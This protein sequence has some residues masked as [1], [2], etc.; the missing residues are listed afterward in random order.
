MGFPTLL[1]GGGCCCCGGAGMDSHPEFQLDMQPADMV[2]SRDALR[3]F[4]CVY[5][6]FAAVRTV[7]FRGVVGWVCASAGVRAAVGVWR[8]SLS[9][10]AVLCR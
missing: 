3:R 1:T 10:A 4:G 9:G 7:I 2:R 8:S 5:A 6:A